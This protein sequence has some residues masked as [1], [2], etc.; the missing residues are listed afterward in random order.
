MPRTVTINTVQGIGDIFWVYQKLAPYFD[1]INLVICCIGFSNVQ[2]RAKAFCKML[3]KVV[4]IEYRQVGPMVY[5]QLACKRC[6]LASVLTSKGAVDYAVNAPLEI[7]IK[8]RDIDPGSRIEEFVNLGLPAQ[9]Q[10]TDQLCVF[11]AGSSGNEV[12]NVEQWLVAIKKLADKMQTKS[13]VLIGADWDK[14][15]QA[16]VLAGLAGYRVTNH[17][18]TLG[19]ADSVNVIRQSKFFIGFQSGLSVIADNYD[20]PQLMMYF[21]KLE[22]MMYSWCKP[23]NI[24]TKFHAATFADNFDTVLACLP[25]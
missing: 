15:I 6:T 20:V 7:G 17:V 13:I 1:V 3:P 19:L 25:C 4:G 14:V 8:L 11:V 2:I 24:K 16:Q 5:H 22:P 9:V 12:W 21:K 23:A 10:R 18:G